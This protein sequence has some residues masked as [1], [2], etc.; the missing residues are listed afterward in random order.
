VAKIPWIVYLI[1]GGGM[2]FT[3]DYLGNDQLNIFKYVGYVFLMA[4]VFKL[5]V[6]FMLG[7][8]RKKLEPR[9]RPEQMPPEQE[10]KARHICQYCKT[11]LPP[12]GRFCPNCGARVRI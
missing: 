2:I 7:K 3:I 11:P 4:G 12:A 8:K 1:V 5:L 10:P 6:F 9:L